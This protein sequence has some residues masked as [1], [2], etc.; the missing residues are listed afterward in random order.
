[1]LLRL[2]AGLALIAHGALHI[3]FI[4]PAPDDADSPFA[5]DESWLVP[6]AIR[7]EV[8][9]GLATVAILAFALLA[10]VA[11]D[12]PRLRYAWRPLI[13]FGAGASLAMLVAYWNPWLIMG[14]IADVALIAVTLA[15]PDWW[16][17]VFD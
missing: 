5:L 13:G 11:W 17:R 12:I 14:L 15:I 10:L 3:G 7:K 8:G 16:N 4:A 2:V 9:L 6:A 1:M